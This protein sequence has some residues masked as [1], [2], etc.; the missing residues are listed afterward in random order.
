MRPIYQW[1]SLTLLL[2]SPLANSSEVVWAN[3]LDNSNLATHDKLAEELVNCNDSDCKRRF[4]PNSIDV[5]RLLNMVRLRNI[6]AVDIAFLSIRFLDGGDLEDMN[7]E[8]GSLSEADPKLFLV[9]LKDHKMTPHQTRR[10]LRMLPL[11]TV[12]D[13]KKKRNIVRNRIRSLSLVDDPDLI[14]VRDK[15]V[16]ILN[17]LLSQL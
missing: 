3:F 8:L 10:L 11:N 13:V 9:N 1:L 12:D 15:S 5:E 6:Q 7:R 17:E 16:S 2:F 14:R 4:A